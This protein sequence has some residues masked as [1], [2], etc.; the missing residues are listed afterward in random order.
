VLKQRDDRGSREEH[1]E[2]QTNK[3]EE[4]EVEKSFL[5]SSSTALT[6]ATKHKNTKPTNGQTQQY[7]TL[8][9]ESFQSNEIII[10]WKQRKVIMDQ[11][12]TPS[13]LDFFVSIFLSFFLSFYGQRL[14]KLIKGFLVQISFSSTEPIQLLVAFCGQASIKQ[15]KQGSCNSGQ[16]IMSAQQK[17]YEAASEL[18]SRP[19][20]RQI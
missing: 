12:A 20:R 18:K 10:R 14:I 16:E 8:I 17:K 6:K 3:Q 5:L 11:S 7:K 19:E 1:Q 9:S 13:L 2:K 15:K 4:Q